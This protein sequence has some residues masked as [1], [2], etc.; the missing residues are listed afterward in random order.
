[1]IDPGALA[2]SA[3]TTTHRGAPAPACAAAR[4]RGPRACSTSM[5]LTDGLLPDAGRCR[6]NGRRHG[7]GGFTPPRV[8]G[9]PDAAVRMSTGVQFIQAFHMASLSASHLSAASSGSMPSV[10][11]SLAMTAMSRLVKFILRTI[12]YAP[13]WDSG[14]PFQT[15]ILR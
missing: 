12:S 14:K 4:P 5:G 2:G 9:S 6:C 7:P 10:S 11:A 8:T 13:G 1:M 15:P 3:R